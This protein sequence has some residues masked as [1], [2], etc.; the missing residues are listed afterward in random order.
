MRTKRRRRRDYTRIYI[1]GAIL[2][3][4]VAAALAHYF[5]DGKE[6][7]PMVAETG[8]ERD[9]QVLHIMIMGVD[10]RADDTGRSDTLMVLTVNKNTGKAELMSVPRDTRVR[11]EDHGYDKINHAYAY[12]G[13]KLT[14]STVEQLLGIPMDYYALIDLSSFEEIIDAIDGIDIDVEKR[15]YYEDPW[16]D[17]G[18]L[19]IDLY[20]G[21]QHM[22]GDKAI[23]Y[24]RFR[25]GEGDIGRI[26]RQQHFMKA[27][28]AKLLTP[29]TLP[30]LPKIIEV[31]SNT[32]ETDMPLSEMVALS[33][34]LPQVREQGLESEMIPGTPAFLADVS[35]WLPD[36]LSLRE[37]VAEEMGQS[38]NEDARKKAQSLAEEYEE[39]LPTGIINLG[40]GTGTK[41]SLKDKVKEEG[42]GTEKADTKSTKKAEG[43][44][45]ISVL[46]INDSGVN[47]AG[48]RMVNKLMA[49]GFNVTGVDTGHKSDRE[50]TIIVTD[51]SNVNWFYGMPFP[52]TIMNGADPMEAVVYV[53]KDFE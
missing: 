9:E 26:G 6:P 51:E 12:G 27:V 3:T 50:H 28:M 38:L 42:S 8:I 44:G 15:M 39:S 36:I 4:V 21:M 31:I 46:V 30:K 29:Y 1:L 35:Y 34:L 49:Q 19:V 23:Q 41:S 22:T 53:G 33:Q 18:G 13:P 16:D 17:N 47:G 45:Q 43:P 7:Q 25:D 10:R 5:L 24:V 32:L 40:E 48:A 11:I 37:M 20:P 2:C 52:C 14:C